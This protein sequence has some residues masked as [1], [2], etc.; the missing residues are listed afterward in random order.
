MTVRVSVD[1]NIV[2]CIPFTIANVTP[3][4]LRKTGAPN[5]EHGFSVKLPAAAA[6]CMLALGKGEHEIS[7]CLC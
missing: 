7:V 6:I 4:N 3:K 1:G 5:P 2:T